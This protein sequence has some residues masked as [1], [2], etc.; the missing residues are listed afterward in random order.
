MITVF[1]V[2]F[3]PL[4]EYHFTLIIGHICTVI[5][6]SIFK[7]ELKKFLARG[8]FADSHFGLSL[9]HES[10]RMGWVISVLKPVSGCELNGSPE[11]NE[12]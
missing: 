6:F 9:P 7:S 4:F 1:A 10:F 8:N 12:M 5:K 11:T 2:S 3:F